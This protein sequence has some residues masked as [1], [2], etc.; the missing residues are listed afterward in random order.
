MA[1]WFLIR[2][3]TPIMVLLLTGQLFLSGCAAR[4]SVAFDR[5]SFDRHRLEAE[6]P[7]GSNVHVERRSGGVDRGSVHAY[8]DSTLVLEFRTSELVGHPDTVSIPFHDIVAVETAA[9]SPARS[10]SALGV[11]AVI[12]VLA[13]A[14][15]V[16]V[17][18]FDPIPSPG[19]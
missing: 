7:P 1:D 10:I 16:V 12:L 17:F 4:H 8:R 5:G 19:G 2:P 9:S 11:A 13:G 14:V 15:A 3:L 6:F 18:G